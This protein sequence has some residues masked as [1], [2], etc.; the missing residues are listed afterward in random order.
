M[1]IKTYKK[2]RATTISTNFKSNEFDCKGNGC[3]EA[4]KIDEQL[5]AYLQDIRTHFNS[6]VNINSAYRCETH[7]KNVGG[8]KSS[9][10]MAGCAADIKVKNVEPAEVAKYAESIGVLGIGL[11]D[12]DKDGHFVH[13]DTRTKKFFWLGHA[14]IPVETFG[15]KEPAAA[16]VEKPKENSIKLPKAAVG[17]NMRYN[18]NNKPLACMQTQ[19]TCYKGTRPMVVK[20]ILWHS[21]GCNNPN[22]KR[23]VQPDDKAIDKEDWLD[24]LGVNKNRNDWNHTQQNAGLN[25]WIGKLDDG[26]IISVQTMPWNYRPWGCGSGAKGSCNSGW[27]QFE[28]CEDDLNSKDY[29]EKAYNEACELTAYLCKL[30]N[31]D[32]KGT[33]RVGDTDVP[34]ILCHQDA[35]KLG[36]GSNH[37]DVTHWFPKYDKSMDSVREDVAK[38]MGISAV[39]DGAEGEMF[40]VRKSWD[41]PKS[42]IGAYSVFENAK[43]ARDNATRE[44]FV[45]NNKGEIV[46]PILPTE[47][48]LNKALKDL[49]IGDRILL[50]TDAK[51]SSGAA[52]PEQVFKQTLYIREFKTGGK[53]G[54]SVTSPKGFVAGTVYATDVEKYIEEA[55]VEPEFEKYLVKVVADVLNVRA[56]AD[57]KYKVTTQIKKGQVY[58]IV[59]EKNGWGRLKSGA[60][61]IHLDYVRKI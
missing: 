56:G 41:N 37:A 17:G 51:Y 5:L 57:T 33:I 6:P 53:I 26:T 32:P 30:Y 54:F 47:E 35:Y 14:Q 1:A 48:E 8:A 40:R 22:L 25:A 61:W 23:Y 21:T 31:I 55:P 2:G 42:Q 45:F 28:I 19:S 10:H 59:G 7:N 12:T 60:G 34:T 29:F 43:R 58:T 50:K 27:I 15:G 39:E 52:I 13:I 36:L 20:G 49:K 3:C 18:E 24:L 46:Y 38:L 11:Y 4:T 16:P 44:Y 9:K